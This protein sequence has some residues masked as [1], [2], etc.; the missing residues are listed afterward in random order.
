[1]TMRHRFPILISR[2]GALLLLPFGVS[3]QHAVI[4]LRDGKMRVEFG[5]MFDETF[6]LEAVEGVER[7]SWPIWAGI[8]PRTNLRGAVGLVGAYSNIVRVRFKE[9]QRVR[10]F[11]VPV[12]CQRLYVS[13]EDAHAFTDALEQHLAQQAGASP[14]GA[15]VHGS[16]A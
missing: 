1:M 3:R 6:D 15:A 16:A 13:L 12:T 14:E 5:P 9:P 8:G 4:Q 11:M 10:L 2:L 7:A